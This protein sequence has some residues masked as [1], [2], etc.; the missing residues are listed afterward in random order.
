MFESKQDDV[1]ILA[2]WINFIQFSGM[3]VCTILKDCNSV[4]SYEI[5]WIFT[6]IVFR[7]TIR[8]IKKCKFQQF[9]LQFVRYLM[10][11]ECNPMG[12]WR[13]TPVILQSSCY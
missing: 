5:A 6:M 7:D 1:L 9:D 8:M 13:I 2:W 11:F 4:M 3:I 12:D 10:E